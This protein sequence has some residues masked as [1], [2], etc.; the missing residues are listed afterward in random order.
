[1]KLEQIAVSLAAVLF[2]GCVV[3]TR[4]QV[5]EMDRVDQELSA[6]ANRGY[7]AGTV[8]QQERGPRKMTRQIIRTDVELP[9]LTE[10]QKSPTKDEQIS[11][12]QGYLMRQS[13]Q[14]EAWIMESEFS[15]PLSEPV[16]ESGEMDFT[17][18]AVEELEPATFEEYIVQ[19]GDTLQSIAA[20]PNVYGKASR[21]VKL[22]EANKDVLKNP[23]KIYPGM[24]I[25]IPSE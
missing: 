19:K 5:V 7:L 3:T 23:N 18:Q 25:K 12:N 6:G 14:P 9:T 17:E 8:P 24:K 15:S 13:G 16:S 11:G 21:W 22:Y 20:K 1:M 4:T 10:L 2:S